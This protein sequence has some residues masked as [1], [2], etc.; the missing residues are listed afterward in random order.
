MQ[1][2]RKTFHSLRTR[3]F[4]LYFIGQL[5]SNTGNWLTSVA[6]TL[7]VLKITGSGLAV[8][9]LAACQFGP[10]LLLSAYA[11]AVVDRSNK[12]KM[13]LIAQILQMLQST[14]LAIA[15]FMPHTSVTALYAL[16]L[17]GGIIL[18]FDN[19]IRRSFVGEMVPPEDISNAVVIYSSIVNAT[20]IIG[21]ALAGVLIITVGYAW[22]FTIDAATYLAV[23]YCIFIMRSNELFTVPPK[24]K[25]KGE[26][27]AGLRYIFATPNLWIS[28]VLLLAIGTLAY[29]FNVT[30]PLFITG[31]LHKST[32]TYTILYSIFSA[33]ALLSALLVAHRGFVKI[34]HIILGAAALGLSM[35][36]LSVVSNIF[37]AAVF[38]FCIGMTSVIYM[39]ASTAII[40]IEAKR[41]MHGRLL[42]LQSVFL[43]G[44]SVIGGPLSGYLADLFSARTPLIFGGFVCV[45]AAGFGWVVNRNYKKTTTTMVE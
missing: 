17:L 29:N 21:P 8:G 19:P 20:R 7:L 26:I 31:P 33:G 15:A 34:K 5:I 28:F 4:R 9:I 1:S 24:P 23:L 43:F 35:I 11:G 25:E 36:L 18:S 37:F 38:I 16:A 27:R 40:Q 44:T 6:L 10:V 12:R 39:T 3:N 2:L 30:L 41:E 32:E 14:G 13:L 45:L 22:C 42:A